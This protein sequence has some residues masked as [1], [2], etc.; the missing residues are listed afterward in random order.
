MFNTRTGTL[1]GET[2]GAAGGKPVFHFHGQL[3]SR[4][5]AGYFHDAAVRA[6]VRLVALD[7][8]GFGRS[9]AK[10]NRTL[11]EWPGAVADVADQLGIDGFGVL[12][13]SAGVKYAA[14]VLL[15]LPDR[16]T[17]A[18]WVSSFGPVDGAGALDGARPRVRMAMG[19]YRASE[20]AGWWSS[21]AT[22]AIMRW[23]LPKVSSQVARMYGERAAPVLLSSVE[24]GASGIHEEYRLMAAP[25]A[26]ELGKIR[27]PVEI[28]HGADDNIAPLR[29][30]ERLARMVPGSRLHVVAGANHVT[31][32]SQH[33]AEILAQE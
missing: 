29:M 14:A 24:Q 33:A 30:A 26:L 9:P 7:R 23:G 2:F 18:R 11:G 21:L 16:I 4:L 6:G 3:S 15:G 28:W 22:G 5:E 12:A 20:R 31:L 27:Q 13:I 17:G 8:P 32:F 10:P 25:W 1:C 19:I